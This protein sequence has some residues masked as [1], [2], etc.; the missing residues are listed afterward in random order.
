[1]HVNLCHWAESLKLMVSEPCTKFLDSP[2]I[3]LTFQ[4][5]RSSYIA[6]EHLVW[7]PDPGA[8]AATAWYRAAALAVEHLN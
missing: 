2:I 3:F 4:A 5:G 7:V 6:P 1:M 8:M